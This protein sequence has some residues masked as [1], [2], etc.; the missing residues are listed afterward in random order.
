MIRILQINMHQS[1]TAHQLLVQFATE[2]K[3][4]IMLISEQYPNRDPTYRV[5]LPSGFGTVFD[6]VFFSKAEVM[7]LPRFGV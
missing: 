5:S 3:A 6:F 2:V 1:G 7:G 4:Y